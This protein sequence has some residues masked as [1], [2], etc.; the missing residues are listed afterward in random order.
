M[1]ETRELAGL[2]TKELADFLE[3]TV[4]TI[5]NYETGRT[6]P[7]MEKVVSIAHLLSVTT[8]QLLCYYI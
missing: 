7:S 3:V 1:Y 2:S 5:N 4:N 6:L 8:D